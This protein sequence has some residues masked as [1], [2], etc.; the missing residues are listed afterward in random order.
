MVG[1]DVA[2]AGG[3]GTYPPHSGGA[4]APPGGTRASCQELADGGP[5]RLA[6][7][8]EGAVDPKSAASFEPEAGRNGPRKRGPACSENAAMARREAP[9]TG[10]GACL[11]CMTR[12]LA[13]H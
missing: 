8:S 9:R 11:N 6:R 13:R 2:P 1:S 10:N 3:D 12:H 4:G 5:L 7:G